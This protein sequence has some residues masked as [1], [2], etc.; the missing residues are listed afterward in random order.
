[1]ATYTAT[2][3]PNDLVEWELPDGV[4]QYELSDGELIPVGNAFALH[5]LIKRGDLD[6]SLKA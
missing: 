4:K 5:E 2:L 6:P 3:T 1:M